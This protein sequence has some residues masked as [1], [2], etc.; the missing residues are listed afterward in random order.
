MEGK[1]FLSLL[2]PLF[3]WLDVLILY[4]SFGTV[5]NGLHRLFT[6]LVVSVVHDLCLSCIV[7]TENLPFREDAQSAICIPRAFA[8]REPAD[9]KKLWQSFLIFISRYLEQSEVLCSV[10]TLPVTIQIPMKYMTYYYTYLLASLDISEILFTEDVVRRNWLLLLTI[11]IGI[12][13]CISPIRS[14]INK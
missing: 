6:G 1:L 7:R 11:T 8:S 10:L 9:A 4:L 12:K 5:S 13:T 3:K 14:I 2:C